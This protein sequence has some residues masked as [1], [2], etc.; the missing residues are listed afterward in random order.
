MKPI[1]R[2]FSLTLMICSALYSA[3]ICP[4]GSLAELIGLGATGCTIGPMTFYNFT[5][6]YLSSGIAPFPASSVLVSERLPPF[7]P[8]LQDGTAGIGF[9][10]FGLT[11]TGMVLE[12]F[13]IGYDVRAPSGF[14]ISDADLLGGTQDDGPSVTGYVQVRGLCSSGASGF[15]GVQPCFVSPGTTQG[16]V[17]DTVSLAS[18][19]TVSPPDTIL[20]SLENDFALQPVPEPTTV[21]LLLS[22]L[23]L[24]KILSV[25][26]IRI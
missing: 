10:N 16:H 3:P 9:S 23:L 11:S 26:R 22:G 1:F 17:Q 4:G 12:T 24:L 8:Y 7:L 6:S 14:T 15:I 5:F 21:L 20:A 25:I 18:R 13:Q 19:S 2:V